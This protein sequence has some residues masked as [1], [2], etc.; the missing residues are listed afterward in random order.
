M[1]PIDLPAYEDFI[2]P[3][4]RESL[5]KDSIPVEGSTVL[6]ETGRG[7]GLETPAALAFTGKL[8]EKLREPLHRILEKRRIDRIFIDERTRACYRFNQDLGY[9]IN[10]PRYRTVLGEE[11]S[12]GRIVV[13]PKNP[14]YCRPGYGEPIAPLPE[15]LQGTHV[16]LFG[17]PDDAKLSINAMNAFHRKVKGEPAIVGEILQNSNQKPFWGADDEDSKTPLRRDL[18]EAGIN[19]TACFEGSI[20]FQ[21][22]KNGKSYSLEKE[23][24]SLPI[25][26]FPGLAIPCT[27]LFHD[28]NP[29]PLH[30]YDFALHLHANRH[31][32]EALSYYVPKLENEEEAA[33]I[34]LMVRTA[35]EMI[36]EETPEYEPGTIRLFIVL[37]NPRAI[38]RAN[39]IMDALHPY[40]AGASLG[41]HDYLASTARLFKND[42][43]YRIPVK[44]DPDIVIKYIKASHD[45]LSEVVG[46]RGGVKIGGMYGILPMENEFTSPS[47]QLTLKGFIRDVIT[48]MKRNL[49]GF[50]VAHPDFVRMGIAL[51]EA[52]KLQDSRPDLL[53]RLVRGLLLPEHQEEILKFIHGPDIRGLDRSDPL[54]PRSLIVADLRE[55]TFIPNHHPDEIRYNV[56]QSLQYLTDWLSGN[57]CVALPAQIQGTAVRVMDDLAT[58]ERSRWEVWH[59][60]HHGRFAIEDFLRIAHEELR[61]IRKDLSD[62]KKIV[63]VKWDERTEKW[64]PV[65]FQLMVKLMTDPD[66][67]EFA[68][69]LLL[70]FTVDTIRNAPDPWSRALSL[71][72]EKYAISPEIERFNRYF[73]IC[74]TTAFAAPLSR[75]PSPDPKIA[76]ALILGLDLQGLNEAASFH[77][78]IGESSRTL[79]GTAAGEQALVLQSTAI[80]REE[81]LQLGS[82]YRRKF[83]FKFLISAKDK[84]GPELLQALNARILRT[85]EEEFETAKKELWSISLKR[86]QP[87]FEESLGTRLE[88]IRKRHGV[89]GF[90][91][92]L[93]GKGAGVQS[94]VSGTAR[95]DGTLVTP[96]TLFEIAS[97]SKSIGTAFALDQFQKTGI[98]LDSPVNR[99]FEKAGSSYRIPS[100]DPDHPEWGDQV[101]IEH[102]MRHNALNQHYVNGVPMDQPFPSIGDLLSGSERFGYSR[103]G[104]RFEPGSSF[105]YSG[106]GFLVLQHLLET[107]MNRPF[108][109]CIDPFFKLLNLTRT[110]AASLNEEGFVYADGFRS[111]GSRVESGRLSFP[112]IAAGMTGTSSDYLRFLGRL[113]EAFHDA[114]ATAPVSHETAVRMLLDTDRASQPFMG[115]NLGTGIFVAEA[116]ANRLAIHQGANDGFRCLSLYCHSGPD[117]GSGLVILCNADR[118]GVSF[119]ADAAQEILRELRMEGIDLSRFE[120]GFDASR[121]PEE[122]VVNLGY[123]ALVFGAFQE[124]LPEIA[125][126]PGALDSLSLH[127][128]AIG[129]RIVS[130]TNQRFARAS[131]LFLPTR[132][133]FDPKAYGR[134]GKIM[135]SW[136]SARHNRRP[137]DEVEFEIQ[138]PSR[139]SFVRFSTRFHLGN[140]APRASLLALDPGAK[141]WIELV[142]E[143]PLD[144][145]SEKR[146][147]TEIQDQEFQRFK[148][149][150]H[151]DGGLSRIGLFANDLPLSE[152]KTFLKSSDATCIRDPEPIPAPLKPLTLSFN[153]TA[154]EVHQ[155]WNSV[156]PGGV[157]DAA[158]AAF[159]G[160]ILGASNEHYGPAVQLISPFPPIHMFDGFESARSR[161]PGHTETIEIQ[162]GR[163]SIPDSIEMDF[164]WFRNNNPRAIRIEA[165]DGSDWKEILALTEVKAFAGN[166]FLKKIHDPTF[167]TKVRITIHPDGGMNRFH[168]LT[169]SWK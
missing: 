104:A 65:A 38:F 27:F 83:G 84:S 110:R 96:D 168:F 95:S 137:F 10:D 92:S 102:L 127:N 68:S 66:P 58:A 128:R 80:L 123:K 91:I 18:I 82:E 29:I 24:L 3:K 108:R 75:L 88:Q 7:G 60:L 129:A 118:N 49:S 115:V 150:M 154:D 4:L 109:E 132:P 14:F 100:I 63:Q 1:K 19:L 62:Q 149:R 41:W 145:H 148:V 50:W 13:G 158:S 76:E 165:S 107:L 97:L 39:E 5:L 25:K 15:P 36:R 48:Q 87:L 81:L 30:L 33:Y 74:G 164:T 34:A 37:E 90:Q 157:V 151:P 26:R 20:G 6:R 143:T 167:F 121:L 54:Y 47:F 166:R 119:V 131:N 78:D 106:G 152:Q 124:D 79:D 67:V 8:Y 11:D 89:A 85:R 159:G 142:P 72:P 163:P 53:E 61:F 125:T 40:F 117:R 153:T 144:G 70:P 94:L 45:L 160:R 130:V 139:I 31:R 120:A 113:S 141:S 51:V 138:A 147:Q 140:Q 55:S 56:F 103:I 23:K 71:D 133:A 77:G 57:G 42:G 134:Q 16:T 146:I 69:A 17:P 44:A 122:E 112:A 126:P 101:K 59:E 9:P 52:W 64:Y 46:S 111:D 93:S 73:S 43:N 12:E 32:K 86:L 28:G 35:E 169:R 155:R 22:P 135:D 21:D 2:S 99:L 161:T 105:Q 162:L 156:A 116:G 136:E 114:E 98:P